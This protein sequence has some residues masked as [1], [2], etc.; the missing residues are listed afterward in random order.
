MILRARIIEIPAH[1]DWTEQ[2]KFGAKRTSGMRVIKTFFS[3]LMAAFIFRP[4]IFFIGLGSVLLLLSLYI[5][6]W[7]FFS[8]IKIM[9]E[10]QMVSHFIDDRFSMAIGLI[11]K[12]RPHA[13]FI[14]GITL[15]AAIQVLSLGFISLQ[16]KRYFEET[17]HINTTLLI[18]S[19][20]GK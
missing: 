15:L 16:N 11:Y 3:G 5:I 6:A 8:T 17:F 7:I 20:S 12:A 9:P 2:N 19:L 14:G 10:I 13:F 1:L 18:K 4:Y